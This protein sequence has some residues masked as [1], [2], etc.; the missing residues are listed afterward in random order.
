MMGEINNFRRSKGLGA[1]STD[2]YTCNFAQTRA[3]EITT[4]FS[5]DGFN[6]RVSSKTLPYP[7]YHLI[8]ENLARVGSYKDVV[9]LWINSSGHNANLSADVSFACVGDVDDFYAY[10]GWKP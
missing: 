10:E 4:N 8:V 2:S 1:V 9:N 5:H 7:P 3:Q 6:Q